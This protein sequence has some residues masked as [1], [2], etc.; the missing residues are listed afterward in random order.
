METVQLQEGR[1]LMGAQPPVAR[2]MGEPAE[3]MGRL[4]EAS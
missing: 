4:A 3:A 1:G 2:G